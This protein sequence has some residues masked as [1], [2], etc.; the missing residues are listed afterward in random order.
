M[1]EIERI[2]EMSPDDMLMLGIKDVAYIKEW[3]AWS[4]SALAARP[5]E[6]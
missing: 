4:T 1:T 5:I 6:A 3:A 2:R